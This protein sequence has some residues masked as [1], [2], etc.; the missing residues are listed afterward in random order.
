MQHIKEHAINTQKKIIAELRENFSSESSREN[1]IEKLNLIVDD[2]EKDC[3][4][5]NADNVNLYYSFMNDEDV[6]KYNVIISQSLENR[7]QEIY[8]K[9]GFINK[10]DQSI[11]PYEFSHYLNGVYAVMGTNKIPFQIIFGVKDLLKPIDEYVSEIKQS[12]QY[13]NYLDNN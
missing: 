10:I 4:T 9:L 1:E 7:L 13:K 5:I 2:Y 11:I 12:E 3:N 6:K 8:T